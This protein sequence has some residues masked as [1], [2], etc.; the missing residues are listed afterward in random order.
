MLSRQSWI[1]VA[2]T[3]W[4]WNHSALN[5]WWVF[6]RLACGCPCLCSRCGEEKKLLISS[7]ADLF[8]ESRRGF[9]C[10]VKQINRWH[11]VRTW[12]IICW[13]ICQPSHFVYVPD[14]FWH[15]WWY[16]IWLK[17]Q[18]SR[19]C[20]STAANNLST[21]MCDWMEYQRTNKWMNE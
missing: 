8:K 12:D 19:W 4:Q 16:A 7:P 6:S 14:L 9:L 2:L 21:V 20:F 5:E 10:A 3:W 1:R 15:Y 13:N 18:R 17:R 11:P